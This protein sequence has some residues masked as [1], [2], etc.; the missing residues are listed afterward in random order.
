MAIQSVQDFVKSRQDLMQKVREN[1]KAAVEGQAPPPE[2]I[3]GHRGELAEQVRERLTS[4]KAAR[5]K[6][7]ERYDKEI[8]RQEEILARLEAEDKEERESFKKAQE[9][10]GEPTEKD[11]K[12]D[13]KVGR[14]G[15]GGP[16]QVTGKV[17]DASGKPL[18]GLRLELFEKD[19][20][21]PSF[22]AKT[23]NKGEFA[24]MDVPAGALT[25]KLYAGDKVIEKKV[26]SR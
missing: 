4:L 17:T 25:V 6:A 7:V 8:R 24:F 21:K 18:P 20:D 13:V 9:E 26:S 2:E 5:A 1:M 23:D 16:R 10:G 11:V 14:A 12:L 19:R 22:T 3:L 15:S